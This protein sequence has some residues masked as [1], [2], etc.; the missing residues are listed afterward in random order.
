[1]SK[2]KQP[3]DW[4]ENVDDP[5]Q[6]T[7]MRK[8]SHKKEMEEAPTH[9]KAIMEKRLDR[10]ER[11]KVTILDPKYLFD[12]SVLGDILE[13][14]RLDEI[15]GCPVYENT[16]FYDDLVAKVKE[17]PDIYLDII[18]D[19]KCKILAPKNC[20]Q[21]LPPETSYSVKANC[22]KERLKFREKSVDVVKDLIAG[23]YRAALEKYSVPNADYVNHELKKEGMTRKKIAP[24]IEE[25]LALKLKGG[26]PALDI[27]L[28]QAEKQKYILQTWHPLTD[29]FDHVNP[30]SGKSNPHTEKLW[31]D[32]SKKFIVKK[33]EPKNQESSSASGGEF[34]DFDLGNK[35]SQ[36]NIVSL[37]QKG[38][39][40]KT[41]LRQ[42]LSSPLPARDLRK[43][44]IGKRRPTKDAR[45]YISGSTSL[46]YLSG[47]GNLKVQVKNKNPVEGEATSGASQS[48]LTDEASK[49]MVGKVGASQSVL[50]TE[51]TIGSAAL[52]ARKHLPATNNQNSA[53]TDTNSKTVQ[54][55][56][57]YDRPENKIPRYN[58]VKNSKLYFDLQDQLKKLLETNCW[59]NL[60]SK[61]LEAQTLFDQCV[62][63]LG[64]PDYVLAKQD[65]FA[66]RVLEENCPRRAKLLTC[67][68]NMGGGDCLID[69]VMQA[70]FGPLSSPSDSNRVLDMR[71]RLA[72]FMVLNRTTLTKEMANQDWMILAKNTYQ[73]TLTYVLGLGED[74]KKK[75]YL[76]MRALYA[77]A[78]MTRITIRLYCPYVNEDFLDTSTMH[79][80]S[81]G[82]EKHQ[83]IDLMFFDVDLG[84]SEEE[85][86]K[87]A[88]RWKRKKKELHHCK[89]LNHFVAMINNSR[90][91][92]KIPIIPDEPLKSEPEPM[93]A[94]IPEIINL[95]GTDDSTVETPM[96]TTS[97]SKEATSGASL[98]VLTD[99]ASESMAGEVGAS[100]SG[101]TAEP[102]IGSIG[103]TEEQLDGCGT[104]KNYGKRFKDDHSGLEFFHTKSR[105]YLL[106]KH[107]DVPDGYT[108]FSTKF[109][110]E[111]GPPKLDSRCK[112][113][114]VFKAA[115]AIKSGECSDPSLPTLRGFS[116]NE[117]EEIEKQKC[118][119]GTF[120]CYF[121]SKTTMPP[122]ETSIVLYRKG[123][124]RSEA[125][126]DARFFTDEREAMAKAYDI[127]FFDAIEGH[128]VFSVDV[129]SPPQEWVQLKARER[130]N[131]PPKAKPIAVIH[132]G[133]MKGQTFAIQV[134]F[135][136]FENEGKSVP[137]RLL[138]IL[139]KSHFTAI[140]SG[141]CED[142]QDLNE[143]AKAT[144]IQG[145]FCGALETG[146]L[147]FFLHPKTCCDL[148]NCS[149]Q[150]GLGAGKK[151]LAEDLDFKQ[152]GDK[153]PI[154]EP[155]WF[156]KGSPHYLDLTRNPETWPVFAHLY[157]RLDVLIPLAYFLKV[158][159]Y[160]AN[161]YMDSLYKEADTAFFG[162][163]VIAMLGTTKVFTKNNPA[164]RSKKEAKTLGPKPFSTASNPLHAPKELGDMKSQT[165]DN[166]LKYT[167]CRRMDNRVTTDLMVETVT[168]PTPEQILARLYK[169]QLHVKYPIV[170]ITFD[171]T[172]TF[173]EKAHVFGWNYDKWQDNDTKIA[174]RHWKKLKAP[175][176][177][178]RCKSPEHCEKDCEEDP[179]TYQCTYPYCCDKGH[180]TESCPVILS[181]CEDCGVLGHDK[182]FHGKD[183]FPYDIVQY[184]WTLKIFARHHQ[185]ANLLNNRE[186]ILVA[187]RSS[188]KE[189]S[190]KFSGYHHSRRDKDDF[191]GLEVK[192][193]PPNAK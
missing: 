88:I 63:S 140:G 33:S 164:V 87:D 146:M 91:V 47:N 141:V 178:L 59:E 186:L 176:I 93:D 81:F 69:A 56:L 34:A 149:C 2:R 65:V 136:G 158:V 1:M 98:S 138:T 4:S 166:Y 17:N 37:K 132:F 116:L 125:R 119:E 111:D 25:R 104:V 85:R 143:W 113:N 30:G 11:F 46:P 86:Q 134:N 64:E 150:S 110:T 103:E 120:Q 12:E 84:K 55:R 172:W 187:P 118:N 24:K 73:E 165:R 32:H 114:C 58:K 190:L 75:S 180:P 51:L 54:G 44:L 171:A 72:C 18:L 160:V 48:V 29:F 76:D 126:G 169:R 22:H 159:K 191:S 152:Y 28:S 192:Y 117:L 27:F 145:G 42:R 38:K 135:N 123:K 36:R 100:Q 133:N 121:G 8:K 49:P 62:H 10:Q 20:Y 50:T 108:C 31:K 185:T 15:Y 183:E 21:Y 39:V 95:E 6:A 13:A 26:L 175:H 67:V 45:D 94:W 35:I 23:K 102:A 43:K 83:K 151:R 74:E 184:F 105:N 106:P 96:D 107:E 193:D 148:H 79:T 189:F 167:P 139:R 109:N 16:I 78:R 80:G 89:N 155:N 124:F 181:R 71:C 153:K 66:Q 112:E 3:E 174:K 57:I 61:C 162:A 137:K 77:L 177:C 122:V 9:Y 157:N 142:L 70:I 68:A 101:L 7:S 99:G 19:L 82:K 14:K 147:Y 168:Y 60:E 115:T 154:P 90:F 97:N 188:S 179:D 41:D 170:P 129:E 163:V 128:Q 52:V 127:G 173:F 156:Q 144:N 53:T 182:S 161:K 130:F 92:S 131:T 40:F 5:S